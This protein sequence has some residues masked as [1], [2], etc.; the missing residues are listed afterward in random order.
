MTDCSAQWSG[1]EFGQGDER[2]PLRLLVS[3]SQVSAEI[4]AIL[5]AWL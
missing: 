2:R 5:A 1:L 4:F 3:P